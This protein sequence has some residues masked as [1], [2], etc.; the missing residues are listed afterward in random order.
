MFRAA[1]DGAKGCDALT[2]ETLDQLSQL[3]TGAT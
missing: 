1:L 3:N 2:S